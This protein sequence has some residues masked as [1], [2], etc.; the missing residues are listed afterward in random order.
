[1]LVTTQPANVATGT[2]VKLHPG[3]TFQDRPKE[4]RAML[5][6]LSHK[7][8]VGNQAAFISQL[9][10]CLKHSGHQAL[11]GALL[12]ELIPTKGPCFASGK[13]D[14]GSS[15]N[16]GLAILTLPTMTFISCQ[17]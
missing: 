11:V 13:C 3:T 1:M 4:M 9:L 12:L 7:H 14:R 6:A 2:S 17:I 8:R 16:R 5:P 10:Q 15:K